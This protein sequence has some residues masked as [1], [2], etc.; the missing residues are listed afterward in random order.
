MQVTNHLSL[1]F[2]RSEVAKLF[3]RMIS[4]SLGLNISQTEASKGTCAYT[5]VTQV[6]IALRLPDP[7]WVGNALP[8][9]KGQ[10]LHTVKYNFPKQE[11]GPISSA[12]DENGN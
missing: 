1:K 9:Q 3:I 4:S 10:K 5:D 6:D 11:Q 2:Y 7:A 12:H 8:A